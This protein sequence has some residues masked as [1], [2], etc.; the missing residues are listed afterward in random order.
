MFGMG[1]PGPR[2]THGEANI[3][4]EEKRMES[5][6]KGVQETVIGVVKPIRYPY[7][8][9]YGGNDKMAREY[10]CDKCGVELEL[11]EI[12]EYT[13]SVRFNNKLIFRS[14]ELCKDCAIELRPSFVALKNAID[15]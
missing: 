14:G 10:Y 9:V 1:N 3:R 6:Q 12:A 8:V 5:S 4:A 15:E 2:R 11:G 13:I 7:Y